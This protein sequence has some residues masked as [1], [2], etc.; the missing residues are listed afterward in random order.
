[1]KK[2][3]LLL[4]IPLLIYGAYKLVYPTYS[5]NQKLTISKGLFLGIL[6]MDAYNQGY[7]KGL[8]HGKTQIGSATKK[9]DSTFV[10]TD[11]TRIQM[12]LLLLKPTLRF[13]V[14]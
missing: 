11:P 4:A 9:T 8:D 3:L 12:I 6:S 1:M 7:N 2:L 13:L 5:W 10:F 14:R